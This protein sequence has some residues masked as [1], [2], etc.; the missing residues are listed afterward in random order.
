MAVVGR[1]WRVQ[2]GRGSA[3]ERGFLV[4]VKTAAAYLAWTTG[5][6]KINHGVIDKTFDK[7]MFDNPA[8]DPEVALAWAVNAKNCPMHNGFSSYQLVFGKNT[9]C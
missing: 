7:V 1:G 3:D 5:L 4:R 9:P 2:L 6:N 8:F